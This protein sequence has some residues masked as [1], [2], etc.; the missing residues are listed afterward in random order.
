LRK[1][2][3]VF[4]RPKTYRTHI[5]ITNKKRTLNVERILLLIVV[6]LLVSIYTQNVI[7]ENNL[8][9]INTSLI[10]TNILLKKQNE[11][12]LLGIQQQQVDKLKLKTA[13]V[14][15]KAQINCLAQNMYH[16]ARGQSTAGIKAVA[17]VTI[18]RSK[19][20]RFPKTICGVVNQT[21]LVKQDD[22]QQPTKKVCQFEWR[23]AEETAKIVDKTSYNRIYSL[24]TSV[25]MHYNRV[26]D[27]TG[28]ALYFHNT[29]VSPDWKNLVRTIQIEDHIF[30]K[31]RQRHNE[32]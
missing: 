29:S 21:T 17:L 16:E 14:K 30:Y 3:N 10:E 26:N 32:I 15:D 12:R 2:A 19:S 11:E 27:I 24:A 28:G 7:V 8:A 18:N 23:C 22:P 6:I 5:E 25:Y 20:G 31:L 9:A 4:G 1:E 13:S